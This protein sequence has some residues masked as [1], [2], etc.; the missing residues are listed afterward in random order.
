[1]TTS[2]LTGTRV[3]LVEDEG[4]ISLLLESLLESLGCRIA[5]LAS[6]LSEADRLAA[7]ADIDVALLDVNVGG[8][9]VYPAAERLV[10]R[11]IPIVFSTGYGAEGLDRRW[12]STPILVKPFTVRQLE[13]M[14]RRALR[15]RSPAGSGA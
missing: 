3:L 10:A 7:S 2:C 9:P 11:G 8:V 1:M 6:T 12:H 4:A 13:N 14:L 15:G 5:G